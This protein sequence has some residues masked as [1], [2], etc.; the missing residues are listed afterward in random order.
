MSIMYTR[1][2]QPMATQAE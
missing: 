2:V 1:T